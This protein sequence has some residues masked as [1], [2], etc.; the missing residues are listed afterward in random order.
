MSGWAIG[1]V[2]AVWLVS[3]PLLLAVAGLHYRRLAARARVREAALAA[4]VKQA[5]EAQQRERQVR[6]ELHREQTWRT[7][8][9]SMPELSAQGRQM[10]EGWS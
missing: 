3:G 9:E 5:E 10:R 7:V 6:Q 2:V 4:A 1:A 8:V